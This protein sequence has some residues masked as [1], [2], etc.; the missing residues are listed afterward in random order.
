MKAIVQSAYGRPHEVLEFSDVDQPV[1][2]EGEVLIENR[3]AAVDIGDWLMLRGLPYFA[4]PGYGLRQPKHPI[5][6]QSVAGVVEAV[7]PNVT[8]YLPGDEVF[9]WCVGG[10]AEHVVTSENALA[11]IPAGTT[12]EEAAAVP[13]SGFAAL[14]SLRDAGQLEPGRSV[15]IIGASG[16][17]GTIAVQ[18][19]KALGAHVTG[20]CSTQSVESVR[21]IGADDV[22]DYTKE[23]I[24]RDGRHYD[25]ILDLA[26]NRPLHELRR[27]LEP[28]GTLVI[29]GGSGGNWFM[30]FGRTVQAVARSPFTRQRL[31]AFFS[32]RTTE[33][34]AV[35]ADL[36]G[37][38][39]ILP[40]LDSTYPLSATADA[41]EHVGGRRA[42]GKT[43]VAI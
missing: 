4:R 28:E 18:I 30:G 14:Q 35:L 23:P 29:V 32:K 43:V 41:L 34:L 12:H 37:S 13:A 25:L 6:G 19:A 42:R 38:R 16:G 5:P 24:T 8:R 21:S 39:K 17:V 9:G 40:V 33:D 20:V 7:G 36:I 2:G 31:K 27:S 15:L 22:I 26:G 1:P 11:P 10:F 3:A